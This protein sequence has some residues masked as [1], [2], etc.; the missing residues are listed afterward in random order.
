MVVLD[1]IYFSADGRFEL[2]LVETFEE[3]ATVV[4]KNLGFEQNDVWYG[5][6]DNFQGCT[7]SFSKRCRYW[8]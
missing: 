1:E 2:R 6:R 5:E 7:H 4:P 3:E 8:P